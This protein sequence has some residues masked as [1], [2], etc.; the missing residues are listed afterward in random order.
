[1]LCPDK[2]ERRIFVC[3]YVR[4]CMYVHTYV[5]SIFIG[6]LCTYLMIHECMWV[7]MF[8][9]VQMYMFRDQK[10]MQGIFLNCSPPYF[11]NQALLLNLEFFVLYIFKY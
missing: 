3:L 9:Q 11:G 8:A 10:S 1:M 5:H 6:W 7:H 2:V 4:V